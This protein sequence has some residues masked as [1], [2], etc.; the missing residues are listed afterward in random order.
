MSFFHHT[1]CTTIPHTN[2]Q[3]PRSSINLFV[4]SFI[5]FYF[6]LF[7]LGFFFF[8][9][10]FTVS[11]AYL[12]MYLPSY[13]IH[14]FTPSIISDSPEGGN[15]SDRAVGAEGRF[16][17]VD[18]CG[19]EWWKRAWS[20]Q[21][22]VLTALS[23]FSFFSSFFFLPFFSLFF[24]FAYT[25]FPYTHTANFTQG[26]PVN[27]YFNLFVFGSCLCFSVLPCYVS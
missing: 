12:F 1:A 5:Y 8:F 3:L 26:P 11:F 6:I 19:T 15:T 27:M 13:I 4:H 21:S 7:Y 23:F 25:Q 18:K 22:F 20:P 17:G 10:K 2:T 16:G 14:L 24:L 9:Y